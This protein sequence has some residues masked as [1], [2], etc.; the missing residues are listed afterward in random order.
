VNL[1]RD[2]AKLACAEYLKIISWSRPLGQLVLLPP[3]NHDFFS[4]STAGRIF[5]ASRSPHLGLYRRTIKIVGPLAPLRHSLRCSSL[6]SSSC[7][8]VGESDS[9][10][11]A[12]EGHHPRSRG[13]PWLGRGVPLRWAP[14]QVEASKTS[15]GLEAAAGSSRF[16]AAH[17]IA[18]NRTARV[19]S[20]VG[21]FIPGKKSTTCFII[22]WGSRGT[23][24]FRIETP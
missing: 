7:T 14:G 10:I 21:L 1:S 2:D 24:P 15:T 9:T 4:A 20:P 18:V 8:T 17:L 23:C 12:M 11:A 3:T 19:D 16:L 22:I 6:F 13:G 5:L